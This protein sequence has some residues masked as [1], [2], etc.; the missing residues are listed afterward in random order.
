MTKTGRQTRPLS[1]SQ[2]RREVIGKVCGGQAKAVRGLH[3]NLAAQLKS[4]ISICDWGTH[5]NFHQAFFLG[6]ALAL[7]GNCRDLDAAI[8]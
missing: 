1:L 7:M 4:G 3:I 5:Q 8:N 6:V 2:G